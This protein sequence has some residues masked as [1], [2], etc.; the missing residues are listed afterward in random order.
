MKKKIFSLSIII[1]LTLIALVGCNNKEIEKEEN[2]TGELSA[3]IEKIY[4]NS[5][6]EDLPMLMNTELT[7]DNV[8]YYL[9][10]SELAFKEGLASEPLVGSI[11]HSVVL[12][13]INNLDDK[14]TVKRE[15]KENVDPYKWICVGVEQ[16]DVIVDSYGD[17]IV[18]IMSKDSA[19]LHEGFKR[20]IE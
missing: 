2:L 5:E 10:I 20:V 14:E 13:R 8:N 9:G 15:I 16:K 3:I 17:I 1:I 19:K 11:P 4:E 7:E 6:L 18:L 12:I